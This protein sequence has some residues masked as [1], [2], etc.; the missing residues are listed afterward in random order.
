MRKLHVVADADGRDDDAQIDGD[1][2]ADQADAIEQIAA[3]GGIDEPDQAVADFEF[4]RVEIE[5][6]FDFFGFLFGGF[7]LFVGGDFDGFFLLARQGHDKQAAAGSENR[8]AG[9]WAGR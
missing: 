3:L 5:E 7:F 6:F 1:L 8:S 2:P 4:H 9:L